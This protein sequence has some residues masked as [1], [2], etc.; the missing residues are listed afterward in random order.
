MIIKP[1][2]GLCNRL[3]VIIS[4]YEK[5][6]V[7]KE[8]LY[9]VWCRDHN[10]NGKYTDFFQV[11]PNCEFLPEDYDK[12]ID[13]HGCSA[14][15]RVTDYRRLKLLPSMIETVVAKRNLL[16]NNY[17]AIHVRRTD[18]IEAAKRRGRYTTDEDFV[19]FIENHKNDVKYLYVAT[20]NIET[21][22]M[23]QKKYPDLIIFPYHEKVKESKRYTSLHDAVLD[24]YVCVFSKYFHFSGQS[25]FSDVIVQIRKN[26]DINH[27]FD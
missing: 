25:S 6:I 10:C 4:Y 12:N 2:G 15:F 3:R 23:F 21:Y 14:F 8:K 13:Y 7:N 26:Q 5:C 27:L 11:L 17:M 22:T 9:I 1:I 19:Q 20:D 16:E 18:H 24:L